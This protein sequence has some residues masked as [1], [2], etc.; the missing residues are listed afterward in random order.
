[1]LCI[2]QSK[3]VFPHDP[4]TSLDV[5]INTRIPQQRP[6]PSITISYSFFRD[7]V[8]F[9]FNASKNSEFSVLRSLN[10]AVIDG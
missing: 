10:V 4:S 6:Y 1:M 5:H 3:V 9:G 7:P 2:R 8:D